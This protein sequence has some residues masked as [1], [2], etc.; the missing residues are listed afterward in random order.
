M[1]KNNGFE[2]MQ[3]GIAMKKYGI[4]YG[5]FEIVKIEICNFNML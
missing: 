1:F 2:S 5:I 4:F 3:N